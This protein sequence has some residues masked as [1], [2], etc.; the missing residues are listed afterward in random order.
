MELSEPWQERVDAVSEWC[1]GRSW[2]ARAAFSLTE[3]SP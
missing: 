2:L 3:S 1:E